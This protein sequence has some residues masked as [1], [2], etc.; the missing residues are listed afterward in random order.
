[1]RVI[2]LLG[3]Q[4]L[5]P[6]LGAAVRALGSEGPIATVTAGW[7]E[8]EGDDAELNA[9][10]DGRGRNLQLYHRWSEVLD[11]DPEYATAERALRDEL[12]ELQAL[13]EVRLDYAMRG[14]DAVQRSNAPP[15]VK[16]PALDDAIEDLR[17]LDEWHLRIVAEARDRFDERWSPGARD[18]VRQHRDEVASQ[19]RECGTLAIAGGHV[20]VLLQ[21]LRLLAVT[22]PAA[23]PQFVIAWSAGAMALTDRVVLFHDFGPQGSTGPEVYD[24]GLGVVSDV[25][26]LPHAR[27]RLRLR[28]AAR[29]AVLARRFAPAHCLVL[30]DGVRV[31]LGPDGALP[32]SARVLTADGDVRPLGQAA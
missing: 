14:I 19:L 31:D 18:A 12:E 23:L 4:R 21:C 26:P 3:P 8:R 6:S 17:R 5:T 32:P 1:M 22:R 15:E 16:D 30:D 20:A 7:R 25:V 29:T 10:L 9:I 27:R 24:F 28:D 2:T 11:A 13:Y